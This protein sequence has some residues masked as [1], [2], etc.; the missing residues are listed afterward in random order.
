LTIPA[1]L[2]RESLEETPQ[3]RPFLEPV[4][5]FVKEMSVL[6]IYTPALSWGW[7]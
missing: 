7:Q 6:C 5:N 4:L 3:C 2:Q 1:T